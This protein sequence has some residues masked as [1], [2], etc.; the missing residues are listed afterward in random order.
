MDYIRTDLALESNEEKAEKSKIPGVTVTERKGSFDVSITDVKIETD[1]G[2]KAIGKAKGTYI[3]IDSS[4]IKNRYAKAEEHVINILA[5]EIKKL[6]KKRER[7]GVLVVGLG[8]RSI[9]PD[10]LG[11]SV[12]DK[13]Y[14]SRHIKVFAPDQADERINEVSAIAPGV[15]GITGLETGEVIKGI[16]DKIKPGIVIAI[17]SLASRK[18]DRISTTFQLTDSGISPGSGIG[19]KR[20]ALNETELGV[21]V[22]AIGV[23]LV[24][25]AATIAGD[26]IEGT[27]R[28]EMIENAEDTRKVF[29]KV[30][31]GIMN[32]N[33]AE[34][35]VTP[36]EIDII[37]EDC[38]RVISSAIN[39]AANDGLTLKDVNKLMH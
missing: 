23:P 4:A 15:L 32:V 20:K 3:T 29:E 33:G 6:M 12:C 25:Y 8:N 36:K 13:T 2:E 22:I 24:V 37:V 35:V 26:L 27:V 39:I 21:P 14:I 1:E 31:E 17:D 19:N 16:I 28:N 7:K 18:L 9:T 11:P 30:I 10:S 5:D 34:M 38:A